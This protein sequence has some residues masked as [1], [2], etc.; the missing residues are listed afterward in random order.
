M[1]WRND[2]SLFLVMSTKK[3]KT[4]NKESLKPKN[5]IKRCGG[6]VGCTNKRSWS[7]KIVLE[8]LKLCFCSSVKPWELW[9][10]SVVLITAKLENML[11]AEL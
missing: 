4:G 8:Y 7:E 9:L 3:F 5:M 2:T 11:K 10:D 1:C 6:Q